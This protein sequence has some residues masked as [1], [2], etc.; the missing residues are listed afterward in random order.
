MAAGEAGAAGGWSVGEARVT[1]V[2]AFELLHAPEESSAA[3]RDS[4]FQVPLRLA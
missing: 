3:S 1:A 2:L 4:G